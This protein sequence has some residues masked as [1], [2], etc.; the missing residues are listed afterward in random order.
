MQTYANKTVKKKKL[1]PFASISFLLEKNK[2]N[3]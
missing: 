1:E 3:K 2:L